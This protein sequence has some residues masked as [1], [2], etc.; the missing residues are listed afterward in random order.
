MTDA[1]HYTLR[2]SVHIRRPAGPSHWACRALEI[3]VG[4]LIKPILLLALVLGGDTSVVNAAPDRLGSISGEARVV[5]GDTLYVG[6]TKVR[7][8]GIDAPETRQI[9]QN[10]NEAEWQC[11]V[12]AAR[13][14]QQEIGRRDVH[15]QRMSYDRN[16]R[17]IAVCWVGHSDLGRRLVQLGLAIAYRKYSH[18]YVSAELEAK[19]LKRG[20]WAG[21]FIEP[22]R[23]RAMQRGP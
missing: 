3:F 12:A 13:A 1:D 23:W 8:H 18:D 19:R 14:L 22:E 21:S 5:D 4:R 2:P 17:S 15:C 20:M 7:L 16:Q 11:G 10:V 9:C 6:D